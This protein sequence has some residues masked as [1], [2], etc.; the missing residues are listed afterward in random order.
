ML[1]IIQVK[2]L[3]LIGVALC[4]ALVVA[5]CGEGAESSTVASFTLKPRP[6]I[7]QGPHSNEVIVKDVIEG[8]GA[9]V[10]TGDTVVVHY[11]S[12][13]YETGEEVESGW[14]KNQP[15]VFKLG[16]GGMLDSWEEGIPGMK[17]GGRRMVVTPTSRDVVPFGTER[18]ETLVSLIDV[19]EVQKAGE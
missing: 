7:P 12:G 13:I 4:G 10:G 14:V 16:S 19:I 2:V 5:G 3:A 8:D 1:K 15:H 6:E 9:E 18:G 17:V 11:V